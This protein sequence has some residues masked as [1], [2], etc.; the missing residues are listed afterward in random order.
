L[1]SESDVI[2]SIALKYYDISTVKTVLLV[3]ILITACTSM[4]IMEY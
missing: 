3:G 2:D 1:G 4:I